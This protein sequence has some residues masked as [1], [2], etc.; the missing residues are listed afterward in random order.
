MGR[1]HRKGGGVEHMG[2]AGLRSKRGGKTL[3][4]GRPE[5]IKLISYY[6][7]RV[8]VGLGRAPLVLWQGGWGKKC[9]WHGSFNKENGRSQAMGNRGHEDCSSGS[10]SQQGAIA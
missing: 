8:I 1:R 5:I 4:L 3:L 6:K 7:G 10:S 9:S 2:K